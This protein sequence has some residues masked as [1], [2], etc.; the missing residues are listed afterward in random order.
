MQDHINSVHVVTAGA[1]G[2]ITITSAEVWT[3]ILAAAIPA[4]VATAYTIWKWRKDA[5]K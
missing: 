1:I 4:I 5:Q 3:K 2:A